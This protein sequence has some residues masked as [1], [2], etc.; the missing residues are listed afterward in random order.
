MSLLV[1]HREDSKVLIIVIQRSEGALIIINLR[2]LCR[3]NVERI[4]NWMQ[5]LRYSA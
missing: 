5:Q 3:T 2:L 1:M 4:F